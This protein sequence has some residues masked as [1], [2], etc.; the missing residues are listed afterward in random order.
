MAGNG[1]ILYKNKAKGSV[2]KQ[3][4]MGLIRAQGQTLPM[5]R[6]KR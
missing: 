3:M 6:V 2:I 4:T 1:S 5:T